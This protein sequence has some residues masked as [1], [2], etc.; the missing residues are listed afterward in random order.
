MNEVRIGRD[1]IVRTKQANDAQDVAAV[2]AKLL[3][4]VDVIQFDHHIA[5][6]GQ[7]FLVSVILK[8]QNYAPKKKG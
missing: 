3:E 1:I 6:A 2:I 8:V 4:G 7:R 5:P